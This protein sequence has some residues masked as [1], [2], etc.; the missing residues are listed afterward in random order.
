MS[1]Q[2]AAFTGD[3]VMAMPS[4]YCAPWNTSLGRLDDVRGAQVTPVVVRKVAVGEHPLPVPIEP[5]TRVRK[6]QAVRVMKCPAGG[7][8]LRAGFGRRDRLNVR[9]DARLLFEWNRIDDVPPCV[10]PAP[11]LRARG[12][13][14]RHRP[15]RPNAPSPIVQER[16]LR[17]LEAG[18]H[19][20][21]IGPHVPQRQL[22]QIA[23]LPRRVLRLPVVREALH[24]TRTQ[25]GRIAQ[26]AAQR[27]FQIAAG[28]P[29]QA[30]ATARRRPVCGAE[31]A[32]GC[33]GR[34]APPG[35]ARGAPGA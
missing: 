19:I 29:M 9:E 24:G 22:R 8:R 2:A 1:D 6:A 31:T 16:G 26:Q 12:P 21:P 5:F 10:I 17:R 14:L 7:L 11:L 13:H 25:R 27:E 28:Q 33:D 15:H 34:T 20:D 23:G 35:P 18:L 3:G 4:R 32:A 30:R